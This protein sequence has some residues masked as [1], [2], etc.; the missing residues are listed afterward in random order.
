[1]ENDPRMIEECSWTI[2]GVELA[3]LASGP[4]DAPVI[5][6]L[7]GWLDNAESFSVL[8]PLLPEYRFIA[9]DLPGHG[10]SGHR[11]P[12]GGYQ[13]WDDLPQLSQLLDRLG[14]EDYILLGHSRGAMIAALLAAARPERVSHLVTLD[15]MVPLAVEDAVFVSQ[16][17]AFMKDRAR[18]SNKK[19]R[20]FAS[21]AEFVER[22]S[23][24]GEPPHVAKLLASRALRQTEDGFEWRGDPLLSGASAVKLN[25]GQIETMLDALKMPVL[26]IW[27]TPAEHMKTFWEAARKL[28]AEK[29]PNL[30]TLDIPGH[31]HWHMEEAPAR[32]MAGAI[33]EFLSRQTP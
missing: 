32:A 20:V 27:A 12:F 22:R 23:R 1:M 24:S 13:I 6:S 28:A 7:H 31:H 11:S 15:G 5:I 29:V 18:L 30:T 17:Q 2:E 25:Q 33:R 16:L 8:R 21:V 26:N 9:L 4:E 10:L 19:T 14:R 3:G